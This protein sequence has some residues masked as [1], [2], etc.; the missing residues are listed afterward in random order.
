MG[1]STFIE[2]NKTAIICEI[3]EDYTSEDKSWKV[4]KGTLVERVACTP[5]KSSDGTEL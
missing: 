5:K 1:K 4:L 2:K 3:T